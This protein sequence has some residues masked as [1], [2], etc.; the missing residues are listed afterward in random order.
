MCGVPTDKSR[1]ILWC[2]WV[3]WNHIK[4]VVFSGAKLIGIR[5]LRDVSSAKDPN[6]LVLALTAFSCY[7]RVDTKD[8][9]LVL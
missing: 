5:F 6:K 1:R 9:D 4:V 7:E 2:S 8:T 3:Y